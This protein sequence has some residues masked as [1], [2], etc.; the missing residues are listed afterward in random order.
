METKINDTTFIAGAVYGPNTNENIGFYDDMHAKLQVIKQ[1]NEII[2]GGDWNCT[3]DSSEVEDNLDV[4]N[5]A[6]IPSKRR[7][8]K[9][10][11]LSDANNLIDPFRALNPE[12]REFT[13][14]PAVREYNNRSRLDFFLVSDTLLGK[15]E[16]CNVAESLASTVFDHKAIHLSF[17]KKIKPNSKNKQILSKFLNNTEMCNTINLAATECHLHHITINNEFSQQHHNTALLALGRCSALLRTINNLRSKE[18]IEQNNNIITLELEGARTNLTIEMQT[19]PPRE[20][21]E[22]QPKNCDD[23]FFFEALCNEIRNAALNQQSILFKQEIA[24]E[25]KLKNEITELKKNLTVNQNEIFAK[26]RL[27]TEHLE[28]VLRSEL[29]DRKKFELLNDEK[30]TPYFMALAKNSKSEASLSD[31]TRDDGSGFNCHDDRTRYITASFSELYKKPMDELIRENCIEDFLGDTLDNNIVTQARLTNEQNLELESDLTIE[32]LDQ[33]INNAKMKSAPGPD[34]YSNKFIH[35]FWDIFRTPLFKITNLCFQR[36]KLTYN[37]KTANIRLIPKK[38][39]IKLLKN[40]RPISLLNCFYK[41]ISRAIGARL[42]KVM[43]QL[44]PIC[45]KGYSPTRRCQEVLINIIE[46]IEECKRRNIKGALL[47]LDI[48]KA[49]DTIGHNFINKVLE[50]YNFG[51]KF[52]KW[53]KLLCMGRT[54]KIILDGGDL[55][56]D[57]NLERGN[58]QGDIISPFIF[59]LGYQILLFKL[60]F[61]LQTEGIVNLPTDPAGAA[62]PQ[63]QVNHVA[64]KVMAMADDANLLVR[65]AV[66]TLERIKEILLAFG[67]LSGLLCNLEK[68]VII[69]IGQVT[70]L[71]N[72]LISTGFCFQDKATIL[73]L[74]IS[75]NMQNFDSAG[76][77][78][79][80]NLRREINFWSRFRLSLPGRINITKSMLYSQLNYTGSFLPFSSAKVNEISSIIENFV[81]GNLKIAQNRIFQDAKLGGLG[82]INVKTFLT[83]QKCSWFRLVPDLDDYWKKLVAA[84]SGGQIFNAR[85]TWFTGFPIIHTLTEA[86]EQLSLEHYKNKENFREA[87]VYNNFNFLHGRRPIKTF[88]DEFFG[89][90]NTDFTTNHRSL[91]LNNIIENGIPKSMHTFTAETGINLTVEKFNKLTAACTAFAIRHTKTNPADKTCSDLRAFITRQKKGSKKIKNTLIN[92]FNIYVPHNIQKYSEI[93]HTVINADTSS[94]INNLWTHQFLDNATRTF[95]FKLHNNTLGYNYTVSKFAPNISPLCTFCSITRNPEDE[96]ETPLHLFFQCRNVEPIIENIY[97]EILGPEDFTNMTRSNFF[98]G[99]NSVNPNKNWVLDII[100]L[101]IKKYLWECKQRKTLPSGINALTILNKKLEIIHK[102]SGKFRKKLDSANINIRF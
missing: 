92:T 37:F 26:E 83:I 17:V 85:K 11:W 6:A 67:N 48:K 94:R 74:E 23:E 16:N 42:K 40:W 31:I 61:D 54:A 90:P 1:N 77:K 93:T 55:G 50:F 8:E 75:N 35:K 14:V 15:I 97:S 29:Q 53:I 66:P 79:I 39:N 87:P 47:S 18:I 89:L 81:K 38:G 19:L 13:Y 69:P 78:I 63:P 57:F 59:L 28:N 76:D 100:N 98:G 60:Q 58:A 51:P 95:S 33:S 71:D 5:M 12:K 36:E 24:L 25:T 52:K 21:L 10:R 65:L 20:L 4:L 45:Q 56:Q 99:F 30:I 68:T 80:A 84:G 32:E 9:L 88:D 86:L 27:L 46:G 101:I 34:G 22:T 73:G 96:R 70:P 64:P 3:W 2:L 49:F 43:D 72:S 62:V 102:I 7:S 41:I 44:T 82:L 91:K